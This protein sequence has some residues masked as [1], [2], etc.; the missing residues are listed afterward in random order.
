[1][2]GCNTRTCVGKESTCTYLEIRAQEEGMEAHACMC[3]A[4]RLS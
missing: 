4:T 2:S 3:L 1:M